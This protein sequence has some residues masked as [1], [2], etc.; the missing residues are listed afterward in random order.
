MNKVKVVTGY[1]PLPVLNVSQQRYHELGSALRR[2]WPHMQLHGG[3]VEQTWLYKYLDK[4]FDMCLPP[5]DPNPPTDRFPNPE[6]MVLSHC[7]Q[8]QKSRWLLDSLE[9]DE[10]KTDIFVWI[11]YGVLKQGMTVEVINYFL[12]TVA[13]EGSTK[14]ISL[15]GI[16]DLAPLDDTCCTDRFCGSIIIVPRDLVK[17]FH[18]EMK[19]MTKR[20]IN[21]T[22]TVSWEINYLARI[23]QE[24]SLPIHQYRASWG[25]SMFTNYRGKE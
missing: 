25:E 9:G 22:H 21:D 2:V 6:T 13:R 7:V 17:R 11:D 24:C 16:S 1:C 18:V 15:P 4:K 19:E 5:S 8:N 14:K 20:R 23:E 3:P 12:V 10:D